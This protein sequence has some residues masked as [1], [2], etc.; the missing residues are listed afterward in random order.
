MAWQEH[1]VSLAEAWDEE[2]KRFKEGEEFILLVNTLREFGGWVGDKVERKFTGY[3]ELKDLLKETLEKATAAMVK[4]QS[5]MRDN[6]GKYWGDYERN[7][8]QCGIFKEIKAAGQI[9]DSNEPAKAKIDTGEA[10]TDTIKDFLKKPVQWWA[11]DWLKKLIDLLFKI[12]DEIL[13]IFSI[14]C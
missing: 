5:E 7:L 6:A 12:I 13:R 10:V 9:L 14:F 8:R 1:L 11:P 4:G 2:N 3:E